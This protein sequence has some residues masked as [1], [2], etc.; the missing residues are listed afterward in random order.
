[1][2][3][4]LHNKIW[5]EKELEFKTIYKNLLTEEY[6]IFTSMKLILHKHLSHCN[7]YFEI[8]C[9]KINEWTLAL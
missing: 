8:F 9:V 2:N 5:I 1:M 7:S 4:H 3:E 6:S